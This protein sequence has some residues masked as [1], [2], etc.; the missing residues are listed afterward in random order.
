MLFRMSCEQEKGIQ[1]HAISKQ[2][3]TDPDN[4]NVLSTKYIQKTRK[5]NVRKNK[6]IK[7]KKT[8]T[9]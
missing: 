1:K 6:R 9:N 3:N 2:C 7:R 8:N 5:H 4:N